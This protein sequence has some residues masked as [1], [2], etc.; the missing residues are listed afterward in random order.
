MHRFRNPEIGASWKE[1]EKICAALILNSEEILEDFPSI[2]PETTS[3]NNT[4]KYTFFLKGVICQ[5]LKNEFSTCLEHLEIIANQSDLLI[6][7]G[8]KIM[9][10]SGTF[11]RINYV[12]ATM[13]LETLAELM[14][15]NTA[16]KFV[17][18]SCDKDIEVNSNIG[19]T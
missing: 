18:K 17:I 19:I 3:K 16:K 12:R 13:I 4:D 14:E 9:I 2:V 1:N 15:D 8:D 5:N 10:I 6:N 11:N 7:G